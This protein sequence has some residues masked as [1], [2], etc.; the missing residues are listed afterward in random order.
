MDFRTVTI[1]PQIHTAL[2]AAF[3]GRHIDGV[4]PLP[5]EPVELRKVAAEVLET[6]SLI[7]DAPTT[8]PLIRE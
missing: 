4:I 7:D 1:G 8:A 5:V 6:A 3:D 2:T